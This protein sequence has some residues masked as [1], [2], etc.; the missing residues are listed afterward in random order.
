MV[1]LVRTAKIIFVLQE[2]GRN[3]ALGLT[4]VPAW[5][6]KVV[7]GAKR[8]NS[9]PPFVVLSG[10]TVPSQSVQARNLVNNPDYNCFQQRI[11]EKPCFY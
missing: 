10:Q 7:S 4:F 3:H 8:M 9:T 11:V 5:D 1:T 2:N 6:K